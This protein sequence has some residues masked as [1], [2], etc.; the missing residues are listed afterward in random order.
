[1]PDAAGAHLRVR[2]F[3]PG[4]HAGLALQHIPKTGN[5]FFLKKP[6]FI[7]QFRHA[8]ADFI[9]TIFFLRLDPERIRLFFFRFQAALQTAQLIFSLCFSS[10]FF[11]P[12]TEEERVFFLFSRSAEQIPVLL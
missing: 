8:D 1:M 2:P 11:Q 5:L 7:A 3:I 4:R 6:L 12:S 9:L 10:L